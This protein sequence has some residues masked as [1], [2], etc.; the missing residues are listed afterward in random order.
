MKLPDISVRRPVTTTM[1][2]LGV[3]LLGFISWTRL[4]Q[5]LFPPITYPQ[6]TV[7]ST[8]ECAAPEE[9]E[10][11]VRKII[12]ESVGTVNNI[13]RISSTSR[14]GLS[15]VMAEFNWGTNMDFAALDV[16]EKIDL[17]KERLPRESGEPIVM[18]FNPFDL[19]IMTLSITGE[20]SP[21]EL[22][23]ISH[24][25]IKDEI[26]KIEGVAQAEISGGEEREILVEIDQARL[27]ASGV[28]LINVVDFLKAANLNY[29]AGT[30]KE[31]FYEYLVRTMGEFKEVKEIAEI[32]TGVDETRSDIRGLRPEALEEEEEPQRRLIFL[33][34]IARVKDTTKERTSIS[35]YNG[36]ENISLFIKKQ[37]GAN[38]LRVANRVRRAVEKLIQELPKGMKIDIVYDSSFVVKEAI[39]G[40]RDAALCGGVLAFFILLFFLRNVRSSLIVT[41]AI[42]ISILAT[43]SLMFFGKISLNMMSL[44]GLAL[45]VGMLVDNAVVVMESIFRAKKGDPKDA[46]IKGA[47]EV[48]NAIIAST[49]TTIC[50]FLPMVFVVGL[51][52]QL[53]KELAF[54]VT[55]S[56]IASS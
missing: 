9:M 44:G 6:I 28:S 37:S 23:E 54:T 2:F 42:P 41:V 32:A 16:R 15:L 19:P 51:T 25:I 10:T 47:N 35:R 20:K 8:Y 36:Q 45:G 4:P 5:E 34:D 49:L 13:K 38:T 39:T 17:I 31:A 27:Q 30:I 43:F 55:F 52:G 3:L 7:A 24:R 22:R 26:E 50:V 11:V 14:E 53:F 29:P 33:K 21:L 12:V 46:A 1:V 56:L 18:K 48:T 40:V